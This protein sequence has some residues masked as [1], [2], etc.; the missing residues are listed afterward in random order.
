MYPLAGF[1]FQAQGYVSKERRFLSDAPFRWFFESLA[2]AGFFPVS[3][4]T[5]G[6]TQGSPPQASYYFSLPRGDLHSDRWGR[7]ALG[8]LGSAHGAQSG[9]AMHPMGSDSTVTV[10]KE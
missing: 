2:V 6:F 4:G 1:A 9:A 3:V 5:Q 10:R 8:S 7:L